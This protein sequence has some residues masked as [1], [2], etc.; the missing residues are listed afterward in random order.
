M[1]PWRFSTGL[2]VLKKSKTW[3]WYITM[4]PKKKKKRNQPRTSVVKTASSLRGF[5]YNHDQQLFDSAIFQ[6][7]GTNNSLIEKPR[8]GG[9]LKI[10]RPTQHWYFWNIVHSPYRSISFGSPV[11]K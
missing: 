2:G 8:T 7:T 11:T 9:S 4:V 5:E 6:R 1:G 10:I 3:F